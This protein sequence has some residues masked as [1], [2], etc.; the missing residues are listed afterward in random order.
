[1]TCLA[2]EWDVDG[3]TADENIDVVR[4]IPLERLQI[5]TDGPWVSVVLDHRVY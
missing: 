1:V 2:R 4:Q 3:P 5:E